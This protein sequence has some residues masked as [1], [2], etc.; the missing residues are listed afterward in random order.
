MFNWVG[1]ARQ[2][3]AW[4]SALNA[5]AMVAPHSHVRRVTRD[6]YSSVGAEPDLQ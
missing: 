6:A 1:G 5:A 3:A 2:S 4:I